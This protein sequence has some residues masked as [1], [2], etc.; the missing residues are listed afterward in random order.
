MLNEVLPVREHLARRKD[1]QAERGGNSPCRRKDV[2]LVECDKI[3]GM[4]MRGSGHDGGIFRVDDLHCPADQIDGRI[5]NIGR[6][7]SV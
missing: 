4:P 6:L 1:D 5:D 2:A 3:I 7:G